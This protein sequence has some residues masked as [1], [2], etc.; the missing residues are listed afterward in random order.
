MTNM[1]P[2]EAALQTAG[3]L[4]RNATTYELALDENEKRVLDIQTPIADL[5]NPDKCPEKALDILAW[6]LSVDIWKNDWPIER[7]RQVCREALACHGLKGR[8][9]CLEKYLG[10]ADCELVSYIAPPQRVYWTGNNTEQKSRWLERLPQ[11]HIKPHYEPQFAKGFIHGRT[12]YDGKYFVKHGSLNSRRRKA[13]YVHNGEEK[14]ITWIEGA[15]PFTPDGIERFA[16]PRLKK[17]KSVFYG[18]YHYGQNAYTSKASNDLETVAVQRAG[19]SGI[20]KAGA[21]VTN[22]QPEI[23]PYKYYVGPKQFAYGL[24]SYSGTAFAR[25]INRPLFWERFHIYIPGESAPNRHAGKVFYGHYRYG[26]KPY[27]GELKVYAPGKISKYHI[28]NRPDGG[29]YINH[30]PEK[31]WDAADAIVK[32]KHKRDSITIDTQVY[33]KVQIGRQLKIGEFKFGEMRRP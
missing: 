24:K 17:P 20:V 8:L 2:L 26:I 13:F 12:A 10:Y 14:E 7:K 33:K 32:G 25:R 28:R 22:A 29:F 18:H 9:A 23:M 3:L 21:K 31:L 16:L 4:P 6:G 5:W 1:A 15:G 19:L 30:R 27:S 11:L